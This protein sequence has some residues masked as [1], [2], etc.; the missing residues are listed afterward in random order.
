MAVGADFVLDLHCA[1]ATLAH[2]YVPEPLVAS[3]KHFGFPFH[4]VIPPLFEGAMDEASF[5]VWWDLQRVIGGGLGGEAFTLEL[6]CH[7]WISLDEA[8]AQ[9][10]QILSYLAAK[11]VVARAPALPEPGPQMA[12]RLADYRNIYAPAG[13]LLDFSPTLG[14]RVPAGGRL[15]RILGFGVHGGHVVEL[16][17]PVDCIPITHLSSASVHQGM[18]V[19]K[20]LTEPYHI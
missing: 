9:A 13:G 8:E 10:K 20:V 1:S 11:G 3:A 15:G 12:C 7:E 2:I 5:Q 16:N 19:M 17:A 14:Q 6:G 18:E 4:L